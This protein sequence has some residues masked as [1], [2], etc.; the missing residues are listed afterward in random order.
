MFVSY[1]TFESQIELSHLLHGA[2]SP[3]ISLPLWADL[4][5]SRVDNG[6]GGLEGH[7][8]PRVLYAS[9]NFRFLPTR[10]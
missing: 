7:S 8:L 6:V 2:H 1:I 9:E 10:F 3:T 5:H 4:D